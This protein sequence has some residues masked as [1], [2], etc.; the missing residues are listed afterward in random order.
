MAMRQREL[1]R[2]NGNVERSRHAHD[3]YLLIGDAVAPQCI[4]RAA[5]QRFHHKLIEARGDDREPQV[6][7]QQ[8][9]LD[10]FR[11]FI[12]HSHSSHLAHEYKLKR[13]SI[14]AIDVAGNLQIEGGQPLKLF[15]S[16]QDAH[17]LQTEILEYL[18]AYAVSSHNG[19]A[20]ALPRRFGI[21]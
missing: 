5:N 1:A 9:S 3:V 2:D 12:R 4:E 7:R 21:Q 10:Y 13:R 16:A 11:L 19:G 14:I 8:F 17:A 18:R 20:D 6:A 15:R